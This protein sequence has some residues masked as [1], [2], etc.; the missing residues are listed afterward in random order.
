[1]AD[2][3]RKI[4]ALRDGK[5]EAVTAVDVADGV[6]RLATAGSNY[7]R[8]YIRHVFRTLF[9]GMGCKRVTMIVAED[10]SEALAM[11]RRTG[12]RVVGRLPQYFD[13]GRAAVMVDMLPA[14]CV[15]R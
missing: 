10:R 8:R 7:A 4:V 15:W 12:F 3:C 6:G 9:D 1:M 13:D 11:A 5:I 2:D 14:D